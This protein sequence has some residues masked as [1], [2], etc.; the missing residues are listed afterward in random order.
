[1][2]T[3]KG[4]II[5]ILIIC[6]L[7]IISFGL[8]LSSGHY[9]HFPFNALYAIKN[10]IQLTTPS[11]Y[12][13]G[14]NYNLDG[15]EPVE[16]SITDSTGVYLTY[17]QS[18]S[19]NNGQIGYIVKNKVF[20]SILGHTF[21]YKDPS[22]GG[23]G[24]NGSV[25]GMVG[26]K[27]IQKGIHDKVIF[28][29]A[30]WDGRTIY[31]LKEGEFFDFLVF[32]Y[33][34]L[35]QKYGRVDGILFHQGESNNTSNGTKNYY[36]DFSD[37]II[38]LNEKGISVPIYLSRTSLCTKKHPINKT[39]TDIQNQ[40]IMDFDIVREGPNTDLLFLESDRT[41]GYCHF[42]FQGN[43]KFS[44]MWVEVLTIKD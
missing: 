14:R 24:R 6:I 20:Q 7:L 31:E 13:Y 25:W 37:F 27:L 23:T 32:N 30:G 36:N 12:N 38:N 26:D 10:G 2:R 43:D 11:A 18:N 42:S 40:I 33:I 17:G 15:L 3:Q 39:L 35:M 22:L 8:G 29:N 4:K 28:S 5:K 16:I 1:M 41:E 21:D 19:V 44:D 9:K 34:T